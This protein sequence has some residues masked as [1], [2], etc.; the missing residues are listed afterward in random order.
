MTIQASQLTGGP[1][2]RFLGSQDPE[3][4]NGQIVDS[5]N[6]LHFAEMDGVMLFKKPT[7]LITPIIIDN[8]KYAMTSIDQKP[9]H[10]IGSW[11]QSTVCDSNG[12][13][14]RAVALGKDYYGLGYGWDQISSRY[15]F[16][17]AG[18]GENKARYVVD[19]K[20]PGEYELFEWHGTL[21]DPPGGQ[22]GSN[23]PYN[24]VHAGGTKSGTI[25]QTK[26]VGKWNSLGKYNFNKGES[27]V[28]I[29]N[30]AN[31]FVISD[32]MR[33]VFTGS[34][35]YQPPESKP[36]SGF[37]GTPCQSNE[38]CDGGSFRYSSDHG[39]LCCVGG[40]CKALEDGQEGGDGDGEGTDNSCVSG[41]GGIP[42]QSDDACVGGGF[43]SSS[44]HG[45]LCCVGGICKQPD[46]SDFNDSCH[47]LEHIEVPATGDVIVSTNI[48]RTNV[49]YLVKTSGTYKYW[50]PNHPEAIAD[51]EWAETTALQKQGWNKGEGAGL[52]SKEH[53][54]DLMINNEAVDWGGYNEN[55]T[56]L[57][58]LTGSNLR[59]SFSIFDMN[60]RDNQGSI[61][62]TIFN[63]SSNRDNEGAIG[64]NTDPSDLNKD[65]LVDI[66]D[67]IL[68][69]RAF[70]T[71]QHDLNGDGVVDVQDLLLIIK[72]L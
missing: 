4:N 43:V 18:N 35:N 49:E 46:S 60:S 63:C 7:T 34:S 28:E 47:F 53:N 21:G 70:G 19:I 51:A 12:Q 68:L 9:V 3:F 62:V 14:C 8:V 45:D 10:Y 58:E 30:A 25:D 66:S 23:V 54:L 38:E 24:I 57:Y 17:V 11:T 71:S 31:G 61:S 2:Y 72:K 48:L 6:P 32:A 20:I 42:C 26:N 65:N 1:Y 15:A 16:S 5:N 41:K 22:V 44:D 56:Y 69:I 67:L 33:F 37:G 36:C 13:K 40:S 59:I 29:S 27:F 39:S 50:Y 55:H 52:Y 64:G